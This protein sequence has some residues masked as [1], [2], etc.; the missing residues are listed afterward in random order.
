[1]GRLRLRPDVPV[2]NPASGEVIA[3]VPRL[4]AGETRRA[5]EAAGRAYPEVGSRTAKSRASILRRLADLMLTIR[6]I[7]HASS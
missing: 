5:I 4:G 2:A 6:T 3:E 7:L 1:M